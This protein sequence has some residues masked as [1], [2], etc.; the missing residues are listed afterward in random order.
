MPFGL[1]FILGYLLS[2][3]VATFSA[4]II[5]IFAYLVDPNPDPYV[6]IGGIFM[7]T[8]IIVFFLLFLA[9][10][11][12]YFSQVFHQIRRIYIGL[13]LVY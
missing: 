6:S 10:R 3:L 11:Q 13:L 8:S 1:H 7:I 5:S 2:V 4:Q 9:I 12:Q